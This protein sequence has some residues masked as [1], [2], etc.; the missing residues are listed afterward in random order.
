[1]VTTY[2]TE[3]W[4]LDHDK[5]ITGSVFT[6]NELY[7]RMQRFK[8]QHAAAIASWEKNYVQQFKV[9]FP[10]TAFLEL[11]KVQS[12]KYCGITPSE[13]EKLGHQQKLFKKSER[14]WSLEI[15]RKNSNFEYSE[16]NCV[17]ACYWCNN[18]KTDEYTFE[19][20]QIIGAAM[21]YVWQKRLS[22]LPKT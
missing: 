12:C 7:H 16:N 15:D 6:V 17:L 13:I 22:H 19:E 20:F 3:Y 18:A 1:M 21:R 11:L 14:G 9:I 2:T 10:E 4:Q 5:K 8:Q